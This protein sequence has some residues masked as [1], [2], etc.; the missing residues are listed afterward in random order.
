MIELTINNKKVKGEKGATVLATALENGIYIPNLCYDKRLKPYAGCRLCL[1]EI[2]GQRELSAACAT[3]IRDGMVVITE[4]DT[5]A[6]ARKTVLEFL[7]LYHPLDCPICDKAGECKLQDIA[8]RY[9][10]HGNR[11]TAVRRKDKERLEAPFVERNPNRCVLCGI[12]VGICNE[13]Q[14]VGALNFIGR[15][16]RTNISPAFEETLDCEFCG[17]CID[18]CPVGALGSK[19]YRHKSRIWYMDEHTIICPF[20]GCGCTIA[21]NT[22]E[23]KIIR[24]RGKEGTGINDGNLCGRGRFGFDFIYSEN[25]LTQ[26][27]IRK[28]GTHEPVTWD[29]AIDYIVK[30]LTDI[31]DKYGPASIGGIG[32]QR[33]TIEDNYMLQFL[34]RDVIGT[35]SIDSAARF[36]Y[37]KALQAFKAA[38]GIDYLPIQWD[39]PLY[40]DFMLIIESD[41]TSTL[42]VWGLNFI[43]SKNAG[44]RLVVV[45][46][47]ETKLARNTADWI[48][49]RPGHGTTFINSLMKVIYDRGLYNREA[50]SGIQNHDKMV[51]FLDNFSLSKAA[52]EVGVDEQIIVSIAEDY[53]RAQKRLIA[54]TSSFSE[55]TKDV[56]ILLAAANLIL[57]MGDSPDQL[58]SPAELCNTL[59]TYFSGVRPQDNG[60]NGYQMMY[61]STELKAL[62]ILGENPLVVFPNLKAVEKR[63][64]GLEFLAVQDIFMTD[65]AKIADVV[66]PACSW[67]EKDGNFLSASGLI[68]GISKISSVVGQSMPDW[69]IL[70]NVARAMTTAPVP[71]TLEEIGVKSKEKIGLSIKGRESFKAFN[72]VEN[73]ILEST[74]SEYPLTL[75]TAN[76]LQHSGALSGLSKNLSAFV[77][78]AFLLVNNIDAERFDIKEGRPIRVTSRRGDVFI[79]PL[80]TNEVPQGCVFAPLHF[81][82]AR[83]NTLTYPSIG[84]GVPL[85]A[86]RLSMD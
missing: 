61:E 17:Q 51:H 13:H 35:D 41:I 28:D 22:R 44:S 20:C 24:S 36:G 71:M 82:H 83:L 49:I 5:I 29:E 80:I 16:F 25:R 14:G 7:L 72:P 57:L 62:Y 70:R 12:C 27:M 40:S 43:H 34:L 38:F 21:V 39:K 67:A 50:L 76:V 63:L 6:E 75:V 55:N 74:D 48:R 42:P 84:Q 64:R 45:D 32:S 58:Q 19:D 33:C 9:G 68:Q 69:M 8:F 60:L 79:K 26:P 10:G 47:K 18:A 11:F 77:P 4:S 59:G 52:S 86:V 46:S 81:I 65:T 1:V 2:E 54:I 85:V 37:A 53:A 56:N 3:Q 73:V 78:D 30:R 31:K 23:N 66:L 15:G